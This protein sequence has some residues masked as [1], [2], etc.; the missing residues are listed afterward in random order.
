MQ[1]IL[2]KYILYNI[3]SCY[4]PQAVH[5]VTSHNFFSLFFCKL[6][7]KYV[8]SSFTYFN[9]LHT[10]FYLL[11]YFLFC[12]S[13]R[14]TF[15]NTICILISNVQRNQAGLKKYCMIFLHSFFSYIKTQPTSS[16]FYVTTWLDC[17]LYFFNLVW[18]IQLKIFLIFLFISL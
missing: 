9:P 15:W 18:F 1:T 2:P 11:A 3:L 5:N 14:S 8:K 12:L 7:K 17:W 13:S 10:Y 6:L 4:K 16:Y